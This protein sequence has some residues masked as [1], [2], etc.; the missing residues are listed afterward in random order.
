MCVSVCVSVDV[1]AFPQRNLSTT[2]LKCDM[3]VLH[4]HCN[5][6]SALGAKV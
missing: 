5:T 4:S 1:C 6:S 2:D 3:G